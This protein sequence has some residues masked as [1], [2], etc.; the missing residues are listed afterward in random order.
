MCDCDDRIEELESTIAQQ[1]GRIK[2]LT[3]KIGMLA[4]EITHH[5]MKRK[6]LSGTLDDLGI[7]VEEIESVLESFDA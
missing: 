4:R 5:Q 3:E 1:N 2:Q 6:S 7:R